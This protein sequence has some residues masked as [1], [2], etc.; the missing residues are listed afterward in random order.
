MKRY[1]KTINYEDIDGKKKSTIVNSEFEQRVLENQIEK[2]MQLKTELD[3]ASWRFKNEIDALQSVTGLKSKNFKQKKP[4]KLDEEIRK[5]SIQKEEKRK[6]EKEKKAKNKEQW[7]KLKGE[8]KY[9]EILKFLL[10]IVILTA[11]FF[12]LGMIMFKL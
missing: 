6:K 7:D 5:K 1:P 10:F 3:V 4:Y 12:I 2:Q 8:E 9:K 11:I